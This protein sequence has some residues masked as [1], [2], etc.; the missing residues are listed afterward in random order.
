MQMMMMMIW[1]KM[2]IQIGIQPVPL[3]RISDFRRS[4]AF[5]GIQCTCKQRRGTVT[6]RGTIM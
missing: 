5:T 4:A 1:I 6:S 2:R 3:Q